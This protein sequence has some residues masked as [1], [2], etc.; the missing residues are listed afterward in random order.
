MRVS[1][2]FFGTVSNELVK[3]D[4]MKSILMT[5]SAVLLVTG[6]AAGHAQ[7][8]CPEDIDAFNRQYE[9]T[10]QNSA[11]GEALS[12]AE[13][14]QLFGLRTAAENLHEAGNAEMCAAVIQRA[15]VVLDSAIAPQVLRPGELIGREVVNTQ[16]ENLGEIE[17]VMI[18]P[19]SGRI[20]Y[21]VIEHG[22]FLGIGDDLFAVPWKAIQF[23]PGNDQSV[24]LDIPEERLENAPR[25]SREDETPLERR[26]WVTSVHNYYG[27][28]P[29][30]QDSVGAM[31]LQYGG[32]TGAAA[33]AQPQT[34]TATET[35]IAPVTV[36]ETEPSTSGTQPATQE[37]GSQPAT[38][39]E[40]QSQPAA[41]QETG[42]QTEEQAPDQ[43]GNQTEP[44]SET[45]P[46][47]QSSAQPQT[48]TA[49]LAAPQD[50]GASD[51]QI[52]TLT[53]RLDQLEQEVRQLSEQ[54]PGEDVTQAISRLEEQMQEMSKGIDEDISQLEERITALGDDGGS[55]AQ[56][57]S[58]QGSSEGG[59]SGQAAT[60]VIVPD[61]ASQGSGQQATETSQPGQSEQSGTPEQ[62]G[63]TE[64]PDQS[65]Q[66]GEA[67]QPGQAGQSA[68]SEQSTAS[69]QSTQ[70]EESTQPGQSDQAGQ[71]GSQ[72]SGEASAEQGATEPEVALQGSTEAATQSEETDVDA[73]SGQPCEEQIAQLEEDLQRAEELGIATSDAE[74]EL[75][76]AQ[77]MLNNNSEALCRAAIK[78]AQEEL[79]AVGFEPTQMN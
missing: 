65:G 24:L 53:D 43:S 76:D 71:T 57:T 7:A 5:T 25:F 27:V 30:W 46:D 13:Q 60:V 74:S 52:A 11:A 62:A 21:V 18:D 55:S 77:A 28:E 63:Q 70:S 45:D 26:E 64:Q 39:Q 15:Q 72:Q 59:Q 56:E 41:Q 68:Q 69:E 61:P 14:A 50:S 17:E 47:S 23:V 37:T 9:E 32:G 19:A 48:G 6:I 34:G 29:Y 67:E 40:T 66:S 31:A 33:G 2:S 51:D 79:V 22:G 3:G 42:S 20:A 4:A 36:T 12:T 38:Q 1:R 54:G 58:Q 10:L 49:A 44:D 75:Q 73:A 16:D 78:R 8:A 35:V